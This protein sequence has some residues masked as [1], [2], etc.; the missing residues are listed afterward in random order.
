[1]LWSS[2]VRYGQKTK[3]FGYIDNMICQ[4]SAAR[5][6]FK[7]LDIKLTMAVSVVSIWFPA[8]CNPW[9]RWWPLSKLVFQLPCSTSRVRPIHSPPGVDRCPSLQNISGATVLFLAT[10]AAAL[11]SEH[12]CGSMQG[13]HQASICSLARRDTDTCILAYATPMAD[14]QVERIL[15]A[16]SRDP[17]RS[18]ALTYPDLPCQQMFQG[19][20]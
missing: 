19:A 6:G 2:G 1:M 18:S 11:A 13:C 7:Q 17:Q 20:L 14:L 12:C 10:L 9:L 3:K 5:Q 8:A 4:V 15:P 16:P